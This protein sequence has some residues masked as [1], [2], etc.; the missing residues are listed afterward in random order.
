ME[1]NR[2]SRPSQPIPPNFWAWLAG[3][4]DGEACF[5][6]THTGGSGTAYAVNYLVVLRA[7][8]W[9]VLQMAQEVSGL[10][11][12]RKRKA[13]GTSHPQV[14]WQVRSLADC[15]ILAAGFDS[16]GGLFAKKNR[17]F[18]IW[19]EAMGLIE[20]YGGGRYSPV[21]TRLGEL[22]KLLHATKVWSPE[23]ATGY[24]L[25]NGAGF[26]RKASGERSIG[27][28]ERVTRG[29]RRMAIASKQYWN[30]E[31][32]REAKVKRQD[33]YAKLT[34][35]QVDGIIARVLDGERRKSLAD[36]YGISVQLVGSLVRGERNR[37]DGS[38]QPLEKHVGPG[39][40]DPA[41][42]ESEAGQRARRN[43]AVARGKLSQAQIDELVSRYEAGGV[44]TYQLAEEYGVSRPLISKF[45]KGDYIRRD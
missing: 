10:G 37:R 24:E 28:M 13:T 5:S 26:T 41:F 40:T 44:T 12:L 18:V 34:Q 31:A 21:G 38:L 19:K 32:G 14:A 17:D 36:E 39:A 22:K 45:I 15:K 43:Q 4:S 2:L 33:R 42:W 27:Q 3:L 23:R 11:D 20:A 6:I 30:S 29:A 7:D 35:G 8:D 1:E 16:A 9:P 25:L